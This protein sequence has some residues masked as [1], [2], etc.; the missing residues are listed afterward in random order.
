MKLL[1][2]TRSDKTVKDWEELTHPIFEKYA[3]RVGADF[4]VLNEK[5]DVHDATGGI[6][7]GVYQYRIME[8]YKLHEEYDRILHLD[9]DMLLTPQCPDLFKLIPYD[10]IGTIF[11]DVGS[12]MPYRRNTILEGQQQFGWIG[13]TEGY[14]N[15]GVFLTSKCHRDIFQPID[16]QYYVEWGTDDIHIGYLIKKN[17]FKVAQLSYHF[18]HMT[19]FSEP[20]N[21]NA[22][23]FNSHI[24]HYAGGGVFD[25]DTV[26]NKMEQAKKDFKVLYPE[27]NEA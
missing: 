22:D 20:W 1:I 10:H 15:T 24:I 23:R 18:N 5:Y 3:K 26:E 8:H 4:K 16:G 13:W 11:E 17:N 7:N 9:N 12:R 14:I 19:M 27:N 25:K 21:G 6:G 2:T